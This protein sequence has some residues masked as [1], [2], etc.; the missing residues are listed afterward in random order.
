MA[1]KPTTD[2]IR[3]PSATFDDLR[4]NV[5]VLTVFEEIDY[6]DYLGVALAAQDCQFVF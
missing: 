6:A 2:G 3:R 1:L 4:D 5:V